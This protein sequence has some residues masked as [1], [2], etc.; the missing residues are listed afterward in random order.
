LPA[1]SEERAGIRPLH[2]TLEEALALLPEGTHRLLDRAEIE[3]YLS[4]LEETPP[5]WTL[6]YGRGHQDPGHDERVFALNRER[7]EKRSAKDALAW[8]L[9]F[10]W[11]GELSTFDAEE[12]GFRVALG[13]KL[14]K[15]GW[16][17]V[18]FKYE[19]LPGSLV[20]TA[21]TETDRLKERIRQGGPVEVDVLL[22]GRLIADESV[23]YGFSHDE[24]GEGL[25]M[26]VVRIESVDYA[27]KRPVDQ[28]P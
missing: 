18:R 6:L 13:P 25:I 22:A 19:E 10:V 14:I 23:I 11:E 20:A 27:L 16:G 7:D 8:R 4:A 24:E 15:T 3:A 17:F 1:S 28:A 5:D 21:G 2:A 26:P 12:Q 9:A